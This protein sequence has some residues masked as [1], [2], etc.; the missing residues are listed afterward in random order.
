MGTENKSKSKTT[1]QT[2]PKFNHERKNNESKQVT[3][4]NETQEETGMMLTTKVRRKHF[5]EKL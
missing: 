2:S 4:E 3:Q 5:D 1:R